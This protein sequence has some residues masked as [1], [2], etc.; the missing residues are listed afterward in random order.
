MEAV[1]LRSAIRT[2]PSGE[3]FIW[4]L[5]SKV[6]SKDLAVLTQ[7]TTFH[8]V[9]TY[10]ERQVG[11][12]IQSRGGWEREYKAGEIV[13]FWKD[14]VSMCQ[15][16][17]Y[18]LAKNSVLFPKRIVDEHDKISQLIRIK[19][20]P[21]MD[22]KIKSVY[23][24]LHNKYYYEDGD[25]LIRPPKDFDDFVQ[26]GIALLHCVCANGYYRSHVEG[27]PLILFVRELK[28]PDNPFYTMQYDVERQIII[29]CYG[30]R[31]STATPEVVQF[32]EQWLRRRT[33]PQKGNAA[34]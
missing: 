23:P 6:D 27:N 20:D 16:L 10:T 2:E 1:N 14:Y 8:K 33:A 34:A 24:A 22:E 13:K 18:N 4:V 25:Y 9:K 17:G 19:H 15:K 29:Q 28:S 12:K 11:I 31:H 21:A 32:T 7:H 5:E 26:E 30:Y 3:E